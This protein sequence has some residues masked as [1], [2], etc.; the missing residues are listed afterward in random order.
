MR[1]IRTLTIVAVML[2]LAVAGSVARQT[3]PTPTVEAGVDPTLCAVEP[4]TL[5]SLEAIVDQ[6]AADG[7]DVRLPIRYAPYDGEPAGDVAASQVTAVLR[8]LAA[9]FN[10]GDW[11]RAYALF[12][13]D[14]LRLALYP[15]DL[16]WAATP[17]P[18]E[19]VDYFAEPVV[20]D[21]R[22]QGDGRVTALVDFDGEVALV[23]FIW[24]EAGERYVIDLWDD[25]LT[26]DVTPPA[27]S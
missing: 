7:T 6:P 3:A 15:E 13:D 19:A 27:E 24:D 10:A 21:V 9:C 25:Q 20:W 1:F 17:V 26:V 4:R 22:V 11:L 14:A 18:L 16:D 8:E 12:S 2:V 5:A 23:T